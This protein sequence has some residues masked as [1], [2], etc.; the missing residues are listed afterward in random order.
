MQILYYVCTTLCISKWR[1]TRYSWCLYSALKFSNLMV[2]TAP[3][4]RIPWFLQSVAFSRSSM[5]IQLGSYCH[6][7]MFF[8][9]FRIRPGI[10]SN[11]FMQNIYVT[12]DTFSIGDLQSV[13]CNASML[14]CLPLSSVF[15]SITGDHWVNKPR[16]KHL[17][18][19]SFFTFDEPF[20]WI[21]PQATPVAPVLLWHN[22]NLQRDTQAR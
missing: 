18:V 9:R 1:W 16:H 20:G 10:H 14:P 5:Q 17:R 7:S 22:K 19:S 15:V 21:C 3:W 8:S 12:F 4:R 2:T 13:V 6:K 11:N